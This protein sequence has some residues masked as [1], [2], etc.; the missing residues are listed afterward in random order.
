[1]SYWQ[2]IKET[3][4]F[5]LETEEVGAKD[6][7]KS[8]ADLRWLVVT[9]FIALILNNISWIIATR[10]PESCPTSVSD[11]N[12]QVALTCPDNWD[13][14][15]VNERLNWVNVLANCETKA[16]ETNSITVHC[17]TEMGGEPV[18]YVRDSYQI[19]VDTAW[20][21]RASLPET[22]FAIC[23]E[24]YY[25]YCYSIEDNACHVAPEDMSRNARNYAL[26]QTNQ[27]LSM[28]SYGIYTA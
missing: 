9:L 25:G 16:L 3:D 28:W 27:Y 17:V 21:S 6:K 7:A 19:V 15:G 8:P 4:S 13:S 14:W 20:L 10:S 22:V 18:Q 11:S 23:R 2:K 5:L 12:A 26:Y 1:M 24:V